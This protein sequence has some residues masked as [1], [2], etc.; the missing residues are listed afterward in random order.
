MCQMIHWRKI[1]QERG[2]ENAKVRQD[3]DFKRDNEKIPQRD[4]NHLSKNLK[5]MGKCISQLRL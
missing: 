3:C 4:R 5:K 2:K 1:K